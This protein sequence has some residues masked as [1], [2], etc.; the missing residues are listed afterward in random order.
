MLVSHIESISSVSWECVLLKINTTVRELAE[1]SLG[2]DGGSLSGILLE[3][4]SIT[5]YVTLQ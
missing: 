5:V 1:R 2:L 4:V 3:N